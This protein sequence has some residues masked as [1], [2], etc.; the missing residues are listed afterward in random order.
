MSNPGDYWKDWKIGFIFVSKIALIFITALILVLGYL[1]ITQLYHQ[2]ATKKAEFDNVQS[3]DASFLLKYPLLNNK[4]RI[5]RIVHSY[6]YSSGYGGGNLELIMMQLEKP[7]SKFPIIGKEEQLRDW[8]RHPLQNQQFKSAL[9]YFI[10][11]V[12]SFNLPWFPKTNIINTKYNFLIWNL[13]TTVKNLPAKSEM[14]IYD[15][16]A[17]VLYYI[18]VKLPGIK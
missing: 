3:I 16:S 9:S 5:V 6:K 11:Y 2:F 14:F 18:N 1:D 7:K 12:Q 15:E 13:S 4:T 17:Y 10:T 8:L